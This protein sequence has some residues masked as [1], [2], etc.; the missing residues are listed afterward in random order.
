MRAMLATEWADPSAMQLR[1]VPDPEPGPGEVLVEVRAIGCNF[2]DILIVQGKYQ[3]KPPLPFSPG[4]EV[5]GVVR[6][7]GAGVTNV[8]PG[9]RVI[10]MLGWG[11]YA[12]L[13]T[14]PA[15]HLF[16]I[17][18]GMGFPE[19]AAFPLVYQTSW[20]ALS[21]RAGLRAGESLLV[22]GAA[23]GVGLAAVQIGKLLG[24][25]VIATAGTAAKLEVAR[26]SGADVLIDYA[27]EDWVERVKAVTEGAGADVIYDPVGG[28][29]FDGSTRCIAFEGRLLV[30]GFAG[31][32]IPTI[33][34]NR[35]LLKN[36]SI[37]GVH[38]GLYQ[39]R[40]S[41]LVDEW[42]ETLFAHYRAGRLRPVVYR[43][44]PLA[45]AARAL[46]ALA[47]REAYG[48]VVLVP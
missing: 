19:A 10:G 9:Q 46:D 41:P 34:A 48:K 32:R 26:Q 39:R 45:E 21:H 15:R 17:P 30:V 35:I 2:P 1:E 27:T 23:G 22:H 12:E 25:R 5:A 8:R 43:T 47:T 38:W 11:G 44:Y 3:V 40:G 7:V 24:A 16:A 36:V 37:V 18:D 33:A 20:C 4:H 14:V 29:V 28:D 31:G 13:A 42:M 6:R